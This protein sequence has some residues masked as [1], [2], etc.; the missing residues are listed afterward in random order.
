MEALG[1]R[2]I[3]VPWKRAEGLSQWLL[4]LLL[5]SCIFIPRFTIGSIGGFYQVSLRIED[6]LLGILGIVTLAGVISRKSSFEI[7]SVEKAFL[8]FLVAAEISILNGLF[9]RTIDKPFLSLLYLLKWVEYFLVFFVTLR[10]FSGNERSVF[11]LRT[12]FLLGISI[13]LYGYWEHF[14]PAAKAVQPNY[15]RLFERPP[16]HGDAN[17]I[18]GLLVLWMGFF[19]GFFLK[20]KGQRQRIFLL[21]SLIFAFFPLLWTYSRKSYFG[22]A[23]ALFFASLFPGVRKKALFLVCLL[24]LLGLNLPTRLAERMSDLGEV[25]SSVDPFHSSWATNWVMWNQAFWNFKQ[26]FLFGSGLGSRHR[27]FY[28]SQYVLILAETGLVGFMTFVLLVGAPIREILG[29]LRQPLNQDQEGKALGWLVGF[30]GLLIHNFSCVSW[31]VSKI[32]IPFW[33]LTAFVLADLKKS[34]PRDS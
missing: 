26:F 21:A 15:Y 30:V 25:F 8:W 29:S 20:A 17:H 31:T 27:L 12:F 1:I 11:F 24:L 13:A 22:L 23:G 10:F 4:F 7:P 33:F 28:E 9:F 19:S 32:A 3:A 6:M 34:I 5:F 2:P 16:F 14:F 18:G